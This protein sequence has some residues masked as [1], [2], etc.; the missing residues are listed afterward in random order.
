MHHII[1]V[2][3]PVVFLLVCISSC[4]QQ[5]KREKQFELYGT[6]KGLNEGKVILCAVDRGIYIRDTFPIVNEQFTI[7][8]TI[9]KKITSYL[10]VLGHRPAVELYLEN[11][12]IT[13]QAQILNL[14]DA[15]ISGSK[16]QE[17]YNCYKVLLRPLKQKQRK[18][19]WIFNGL[20]IKTDKDRAKFEEDMKLINSEINHAHSQY[21]MKYPGSYHSTVLLKKK[22]FGASA[23]QMQACLDTLP[24]LLTKQPEV[25]E[26]QKKVEQML[27]VEKGVK[28][29]ISEASNVIYKVDQSY[30]GSDL[31]DIIYLAAYKNNDLCALRKNGQIQIIASDGKIKK[32]FKPEIKGRPSSLAVDELGNIYMCSAQIKKVKKKIRGKVIER[33]TTEGVVCT[34]F[35]IAG[36]TIN[37]FSFPEMNAASGI[38]VFKNQII[39][40][41]CMKAKITMF[42][43]K[44]GSKLSEM[45]NMRPCCGI[46]D[47]SI[48]AKNQI[49]VAN[50]GAFRVQGYDMS[51]KSILAFGQRGKS[52]NDFHGCCNPVSVASLSNGAIV[53][54]EKDPTRIK[55]YSKDG[56]K[57]IE[58]I[59]ELV[60]G[61]S[62]IPMI[63][64]SKDNLYL[65]SQEKGIIKCISVKS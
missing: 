45:E 32:A 18:T 52:L 36:K 63:V 47:F 30:K 49:I 65:A 53:T 44:T 28:E 14:Q 64:D 25:Q 40:S 54:V 51:G 29:I 31:K 42:D 3:I 37:E 57:Q 4:K 60:K 9:P 62:Y 5:E 21:I 15:K 61:C 12:S 2:L 50:L 41:D 16:L 38:R 10:E 20:E 35:D 26:I 24:E 22:F 34:V 13:L 19:R 59:E 39:I 33:E 17:E 43:K 7:K 1:K 6:I 55:I 23:K 48:T 58:G 56:A 8:R 27:T 11:D 46:L